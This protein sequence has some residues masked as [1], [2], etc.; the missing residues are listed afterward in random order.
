MVLLFY[1]CLLRHLPV[2]CSRVHSRRIVQA[3]HVRLASLNVCWRCCFAD[4]S[5]CNPGR[6]CPPLHQP[7]D[8]VQGE[9]A[10]CSSNTCCLGQMHCRQYH[11]NNQPTADVTCMTTT[12][13]S[14]VQQY[15][16]T[17]VHMGCMDQHVIHCCQ[18]PCSSTADTIII[19]SNTVTYAS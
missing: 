4:H 18:H 7:L 13:H 12:R 9:R 14:N 6:G 1:C 8:C 3:Q 17:A 2:V 15:E 5:L 10:S 11:R 16:A 19:P